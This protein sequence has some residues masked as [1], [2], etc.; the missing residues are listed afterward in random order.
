MTVLIS[1]AVRAGAEVVLIQ[2]PSM[3]QEKDGWK[4]K[5]RD[6]NFIYINSSDNDRPYVLIAI[7][8]IRKG[9][10]MKGNRLQKE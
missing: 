5:I 7:L 10:P 8:R 2:E 9:M 6:P 1:A 3:R 4:A